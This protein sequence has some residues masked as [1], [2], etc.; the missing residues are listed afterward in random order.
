VKWFDL[1]PARCAIEISVAQRF[2]SE[3]VSSTDEG[4]AA[5]QGTYSLQLN[6]GHELGK[7][8]IRIVYPEGFPKRS[9]HPSVYLESYPA[10]WSIGHDAPESHIEPDGRMCLYVPIESG[11][12]FTNPQESEKLFEHL[13]TFLLSERFYQRDFLTLGRKAKWPGPDRA[14]GM[15]GVIEALREKGIVIGRN[16]DCFCGSGRKLKRC[17]L[18]EYKSFKLTYVT[19]WRKKK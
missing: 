7:F 3:V 1:N 15:K 11:L 17:H 18:E 12:D 16:S 13:H 10:T 8:A 2:L 19:P 4:I 6:C 9:G 5:I 14:H